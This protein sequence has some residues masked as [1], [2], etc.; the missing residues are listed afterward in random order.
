MNPNKTG[1]VEPFNTASS[2]KKKMENVVKI[3]GWDSSESDLDSRVQIRPLEAQG[4][5]DVRRN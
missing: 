3:A 5:L 4:Y 1:P 2:T